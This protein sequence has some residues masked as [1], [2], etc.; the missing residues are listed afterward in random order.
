[1]KVT[2]CDKCMKEVK[3]PSVFESHIIRNCFHSVDDVGTGGVWERKAISFD[4]CDDCA[5]RV[6][7][8]IIGLTTGGGPD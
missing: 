8:W 3:D 4:L 5:K 6:E 1:M 7:Y 2:K